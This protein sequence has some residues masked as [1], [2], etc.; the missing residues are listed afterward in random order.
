M[1]KIIYALTSLVL[2]VSFQNCS[3]QKLSGVAA[4]GSQEGSGNRPL[5]LGNTDDEASGAT[6]QTGGPNCR[7]QLHTTTLPIKPVFIVDVSGSNKWKDDDQ[8]IPGSDPKR[9]VRGDSI[10]RFFNTYKAKANFGWSF[11]TFSGRTRTQP[12]ITTLLGMGNAA[13]M[14]QSIQTFRSMADNGFTPYIAA[15]NA[16]KANIQ[17]DSGRAPNTKYVIVFLSDGLPTDEDNQNTLNAKVSEVVN[18]LP[19]GSISFNAVYYGA[20]DPDAS[21]RMKTMA[22]V[23]GG[24]FLDTNANPTGTNFLISDLVII[25]GVVCN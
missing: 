22:Q 10:E 25:P 16:A 1:N 4:T 15:L 5:N 7:N 14:S 9:I 18:V 6:T 17:N 3:E 19:A 21:N 2:V 8:T 12:S 11:T 23:G 24:N 13:A 20:V